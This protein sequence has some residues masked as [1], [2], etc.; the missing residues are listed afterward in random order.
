M[1]K[2]YLLALILTF[3]LFMSAC[4]SMNASIKTDQPKTLNVKQTK[5]IKN[6]EIKV[7]PRLDHKKWVYDT[8]I[9]YLGDKNVQHLTVIYYD[10]TKVD[11]EEVKPKTPLESY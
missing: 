8:S 7:T 2:R 6:W 5:V 11:Y 10:K 9:K 1:K 4:K 3:C